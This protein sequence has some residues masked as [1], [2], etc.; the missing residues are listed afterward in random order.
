[1]TNLARHLC[2]A[3]TFCIATTFIVFAA[4]ERLKNFGVQY[5]KFAY[6]VGHIFFL[7]ENKKL[8]RSN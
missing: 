2:I 5:F 1:M 8:T 6:P 3:A 4:H 7:L